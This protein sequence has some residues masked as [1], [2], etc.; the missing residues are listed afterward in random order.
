MNLFDL[1]FE[2]DIVFLT[3]NKPKG[4][5]QKLGNRTVLRS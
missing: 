3:A 5:S 2:N 4:K 1:D